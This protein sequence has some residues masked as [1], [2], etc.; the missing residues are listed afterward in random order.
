MTIGKESFAA[1][2]PER[3]RLASLLPLLLGRRGLG[4]GGCLLALPPRFVERR[5][6][7][8]INEPDSGN[9]LSH[10]AN[11]GARVTKDGLLSLT[12]SSK[13]GEGIPAT[14]L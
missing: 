10:P 11:S 2:T 9:S 4:R 6:A 14:A 8:V 12:L 7:N 1:H 3:Q 13:G 5:P